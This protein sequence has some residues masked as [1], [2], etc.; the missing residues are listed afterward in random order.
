MANKTIYVADEK[1]WKDAKRLAGEQG[2]SSVIADALRRFVDEQRLQREGV[3]DF[4]FEAGFR[5][6]DRIAFKGKF[7]ASRK[8]TVEMGEEVWPQE[9]FDGVDVIPVVIDVYRTIKGTFIVVGELVGHA[10]NLPVYG[11]THST[12]QSLRNDKVLTTIDARD[13]AHLLDAVSL[14]AADDW[15]TWID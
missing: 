1:L 9:A 15:A 6:A 3:E 7:I 14:A 8:S 13:R 11:A 4:R 10:D 12:V 5:G 2:V